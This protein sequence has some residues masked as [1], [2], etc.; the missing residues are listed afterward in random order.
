MRH[1]VTR[2]IDRALGVVVGLN[3]EPVLI[4]RAL[5]LLGAVEDAAQF[6]VRPDLRPARVAVAAQRV[7]E[8]VRGGLVVVLREEDL[9]YPVGRERRI[10]VRVQS[11][12]VLDQRAGKIALRDHLLAAEY[13]YLYGEVGGGF[14]NPSLRVDRDLAG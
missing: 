5:A 1:Q 6:N 10:L 13:G 12:L 14:Q 7:A 3:A 4:Y 8:A 2:F 11:L 9:A